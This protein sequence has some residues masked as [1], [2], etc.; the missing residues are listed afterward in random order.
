MKTR[1]FDTTALTEFNPRNICFAEQ[2]ADEAPA[3]GGSESEAPEAEEAEVLQFEDDE[4]APKEGD[5][6]HDELEIGPQKYKVPKPVKEAW[7]GVQKSTQADKEAIAAEKKAVA[8]QKARYEE[9]MR[10]AASYVKE[11]GKI[12]SINEQIA[13]YEK[14][15]PADWMAWATQ[16][17]AAAQK[18]QLG[19]NALV[20]EK[21]KLL[22]SVQ[23]K[24]E[25]I[26]AQRER[27]EREFNEKAEREVAARVKDWSPAKKEALVKLASE[28]GVAPELINQ[29]MRIPAFVGFMDE[30]RQFREAKARA[31]KIAEEAKQKRAEEGGNPEPVTRTRGNTGSTNSLGDNVSMET[32]AKNFTKR[33]AAKGRR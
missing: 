24:E 16:D 19:Y 9:N 14:L 17:A 1:L 29:A 23:E 25:G 26:R 20:Q 4:P 21:T 13:D 3:G 28:G 12:E 2:D 7:N 5:D 10:V 18:A 30:V 22:R 15:T 6:D 33:L 27:E 8:E 31:K 32:F 11:I